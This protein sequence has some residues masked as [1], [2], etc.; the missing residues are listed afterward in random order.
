MR[1]RERIENWEKEN[2]SSFATLSTKTKGRKNDE[3]PCE[4]RTEFQKDRDKILHCLSFR[5]LKHKTQVYLSTSGETFRTR[6]THT[7]EVAS[8]ARYIARALNLN[9]DLVEAIALG[10]DLGHTPFGHVGE[11]VL[12]NMTPFAF[13]HNIQ[14]LRVVEVLENQGKGLNLTHEVKQGI[15]QHSKGTSSIIE[16]Y[17][18][19]SKSVKKA[20]TMEGEV[21]QFADWFAYINHDVDD[22]FNM[23]II[24]AE[25]LPEN[26][27]KVLGFNFEQ[28][29]VTILTDVI[30]SS[31]DKRHIYMSPEILTATDELRQF[32]YDHVYILPKV[33]KREEMAEEIMTSLYG[34]YLA[35]Y[36]EIFEDMPFLRGESSERI[37]CDF[38][39][40]LTDKKAQEFYKLHTAGN[41]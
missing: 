5:L 15:V 33:A 31:T 36:E 17:D 13:H 10:H 39:A 41:Q 21:V 23:G 30:N 8:I 20:T 37:T 19:S 38:I 22:A 28:R 2:L 14:S 25:D 3:D 27:Y 1:I 29:L 24:K 6:L 16:M 26:T 34:H 9:Q 35:N 11:E 18:E 40:S 12:D 7:L 4:I 32:L